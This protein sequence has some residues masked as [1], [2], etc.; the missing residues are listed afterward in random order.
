MRAREPD[1]SGY[2]ENDGVNIYYEVHGNGAPTVMLMPTWTIIHS[3]FWKL[4]IPYL[5]R[6]FRVVT[7]DGPGNGPSDRPADSAPYRVEAVSR[8]AL[9]VMDATDTEAA[10]LVSLSMGAQ[11]ALHFMAHQPERVRGSVFIGPALPLAPPSKQGRIIQENFD[12]PYT[13]TEGWLKYNRYYWLEHYE[14]FLWF[15]FGQCFTEPHSTKQIEDC[16]RWGHKT[17]P[18]VLLTARQ[19]PAPDEA[20]IRDWCARSHCPVLVIHGDKD[21]IIPFAV[22]K[23]LARLANG[24]LLELKGSGHL[25]LARDP[26]RVNLTIREF[27][28]SLTPKRAASGQKP[29]KEYTDASA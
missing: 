10:V 15:F 25:P 29:R 8:A 13:S 12:Q 1:Q 18:E 2:I 19:N 26:V 24:Q 7:F 20:I 4:Q 9:K 11:W 16:V 21:A 23:E 6:H 17:T 3:R 22:G 28:D 27:V 14:D 5:A